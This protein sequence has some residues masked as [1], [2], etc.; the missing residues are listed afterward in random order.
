MYVLH[1]LGS[2]TI[3]KKYFDIPKL[4]IPSAVLRGVCETL[5]RKIFRNLL[6]TMLDGIKAEFGHRIGLVFGGDFQPMTGRVSNLFA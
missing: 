4:E 3:R 5:G 6:K 1:I 2:S